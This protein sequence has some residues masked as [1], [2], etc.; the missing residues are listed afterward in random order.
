METY[1]ISDVLTKETL[2]VLTEHVHVNP[3]KL[4]RTSSVPQ[5]WP[6]RY[7]GQKAML[8]HSPLNNPSPSFAAVVHAVKHLCATGSSHMWG[9]A[10]M[11]HVQANSALLNKQD[12][13]LQRSENRKHGQGVLSLAMYMVWVSGG[14]YSKCCS[15][16]P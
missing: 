6:L 1:I 14:V 5:S 12:V 16:T 13:T 2:V 11:T 4:Q 15:S 7:C 9:A 10:A 8:S 3:I